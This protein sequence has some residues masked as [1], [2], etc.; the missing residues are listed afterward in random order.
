MIRAMIGTVAVL[1]GFAVVERSV[2]AS[3]GQ[4]GTCAATDVYT[5]LRHGEF[6]PLHAE[7]TL[8]APVTGRVEARPVGPEGARTV[9]RLSGS[10]G[11]WARITT[12]EG[13]AQGW[14]PADLLMVDARVSGPLNVHSRPGAMGVK[15]ATLDGEEDTFRVLGCR[16]TWLHVISAGTGDAWIDRWC[17]RDEGCRG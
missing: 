10:Q 15:L 7:P 11:G 17:A 16:G 9:V 14:M 5:W 12:S 1:A 8:N 13:Q 2:D 6:V 3:T 4:G